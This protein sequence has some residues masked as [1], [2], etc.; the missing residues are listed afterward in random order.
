MRTTG[1]ARCMQFTDYRREILCIGRAFGR[2]NRSSWHGRDTCRG[3][4]QLGKS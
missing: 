4:E 1:R 3:A 2:D